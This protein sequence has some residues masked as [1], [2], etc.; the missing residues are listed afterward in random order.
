[1]GVRKDIPI[2]VRNKIVSLLQHT[3]FTK[4]E[5]ARKFG[6]SAKTV[7]RLSS[8][9]LLHK[10][11]EADRIGKCGRKRCTTFREDRVIIRTARENR[12]LSCLDELKKKISERGVEV[13]I[14]TLRRRFR[15]FG[16]IARKPPRKPMLTPAMIKKRISWAKMYKN[17]TME[18]WNK[19]IFSDESTFVILDD[20]SQF[21]RRRKGEEL[22]E[23]CV[24][25]TVK[26]PTFVMMWGCIS[27]K[28]VGA[29]YPVVGTMRQDQYR[30]VLESRLIPQIERWF[31]NAEE[32]TFMHDGAPCHT[33]K[34][35]KTYL[36]GK[37]IPVLAWPGNS[38]DM[39]PI[40]NIWAILK[41]RM[42]KE[43]VTN[44]VDLIKRIINVWFHDPEVTSAVKS[45]IESMPKRIKE[46]LRCNGQRTKY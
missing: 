11:I 34:S 12:K 3:S 28:G 19:V 45:C 40:E 20:K 1:M 18:D 16:F 26:H 21:V 5:I 8:K 36:Q 30:K 39:N 24:V 14:A 38:P 33:A 41:R 22:H 4:A 44:R 2:D 17:W 23:D 27:S 10:P 13:T 7:Y 42:A 6:V 32:F 15:Q 37:N 25:S 9:Q 29:L 31:G 43:R 46:V 35:V